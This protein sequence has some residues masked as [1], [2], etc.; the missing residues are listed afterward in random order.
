MRYKLLVVL[1]LL[2]A[3]AA[4]CFAQKQTTKKY[5]AALLIQINTEQ[6]RI[7][8]LRRANR[9]KEADEAAEDAKKAAEAMM[10][11][12]R[13]NFTFCPVY[14][15][16]DTNREKIQ[17]K[18]F[19][20]ALTDLNGNVVSIIPVKYAV[21]WYGR[22]L[23]QAR[24]KSK[25]K[26]TSAYTYDPQSRSLVGLV[27]ADDAFMQ[28]NYLYRLEDYK[29]AKARAR[30]N[31]TSK[32][33]EIEYRPFAGTL[34]RKLSENSRKMQRKKVVRIRHGRRIESK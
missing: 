2:A 7:H 10:A 8:A 6:S 4:N 17:S 23:T 1:I 21:A 11:D 25:V 26:D 22:P 12:F 31:Y 32:H 16:V 24:Y 5:P 27:I 30:Y 14:Y 3:F 13:D 15:F 28:L 29:P 20:G 9:N 18:Q 19:D 33:F 34:D